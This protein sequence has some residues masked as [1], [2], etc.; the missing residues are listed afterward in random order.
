[1][2]VLHVQWGSFLGVRGFSERYVVFTV[3]V[4]ECGT[5][6][7][8]CGRTVLQVDPSARFQAEG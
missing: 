4:R 5:R 6:A 2:Q 8:F 7:E 3:F 1:M